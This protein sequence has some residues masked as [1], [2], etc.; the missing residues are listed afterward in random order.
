MPH[1]KPKYSLF[2][3]A[4]YALNGLIEVTK[5]E[6]AFQLELFFFL[7]MSGI[8]YFLPINFV[9]KVVLFVSLFIP[10]MAELINSSIERVVDLVT[11][12]YH[13]LAKYAKDAASALVLVSIITTTIIWVATLSLAFNIVS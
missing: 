1:N 10:L 5:H 12:D 13:I 11:K 4:T 2:S 8:S 9:Y 6:K 7:L 3:N